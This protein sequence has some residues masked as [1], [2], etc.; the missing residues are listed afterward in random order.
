MTMKLGSMG[1][2]AAL[3]I[4]MGSVACAEAPVPELGGARSASSGDDES[5]DTGRA[6]KSKDRGSKSDDVGSDDADDESG[7]A[8][9]P[10]SSKPDT[11]SSDPS[12]V[13]PTIEV[14]FAASAG[15]KFG[16][17]PIHR[18]CSD[19]GADFNQATV[20][21]GTSMALVDVNTQKVLVKVEGA[22]LKAIKD[23]LLSGSGKLKIELPGS[24]GGGVPAQAAEYAIIMGGDSRFGSPAACGESL[25]PKDEQ[26]RGVKG[27]AGRFP[28]GRTIVFDRGVGGT[29]C[30][31]VGF[32]QAYYDASKGI[33][34]ARPS[35][36]IVIAADD[37]G[38]AG[39][40]KGNGYPGCDAHASPLVLDL[41]G[42]GVE[43]S[44]ARADVFDIDGNGTRDAMSWVSSNDTPFLVRDANGNGLVD[45]ATELF[46]NHTDR[47]SQNGF[48]ALSH[49][50]DVPDG[51][52]DAKDA[53]WASLRLWF[54]RDHDGVTGPGELETLE[55][56]GITSLATTYVSTSERLMSG[57]TFAGSIRQRGAAT[58]G[59][60]RSVPVLDVWFERSF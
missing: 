55:A 6:S 33:V 35:S 47:T 7:T 34:Y 32:L 9:K 37:E 59:D 39:F 24:D 27:S 40:P 52:I 46:G 44:K 28:T 4:A 42:S 56:R 43:L 18:S 10:A 29:G 3:V 31:I 58:T 26:D 53:V 38:R 11:D 22:A 16:N 19:M 21:D 23:E 15:Q 49:F 12:T 8:A 25:A 2:L 50:D 13:A 57:G 60:G 54:D 48:D 30:G 41:S 5:D 20:A 1:V 45:G 14:S 17:V 36:P 51:V